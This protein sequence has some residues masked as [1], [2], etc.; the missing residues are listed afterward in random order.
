MSFNPV[1]SKQAQEGIFSRKTK[2]ECH[3][4]LAFNNN[5]VPETNSQKH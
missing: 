1:P 3:L 4:R 2:E 5:N